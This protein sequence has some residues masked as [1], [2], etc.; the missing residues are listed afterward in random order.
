M[1][2]FYRTSGTYGCFSNFFQADVNWQGLKWRSS[3]HA[4]QAAKFS[5]DQPYPGENI[6]IREKIRKTSSCRAAK[7]I[8]SN[9]S[10]GILANW[11]DVK[12]GIMLEIV[13]AKFSQ[14]ESFKQLLL[15][16]GDEELIEDS[17][18]ITSGDVARMGKNWL[19]KVLMEIREEFR[20]KLNTK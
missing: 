15:N 19:G 2:K 8:G 14:R 18:L 5:P 16:T 7:D 13:R 17:P 3:E 11:D 20:R 4:Y 1:I 10:L 6:T 9:R 12:Y